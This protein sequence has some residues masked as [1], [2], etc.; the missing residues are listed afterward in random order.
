VAEDW[1]EGEEAA[2]REREGE[3]VTDLDLVGEL[4]MDTVREATLHR[5]GELE[6]VDRGDRDPPWEGDLE[7][8]G[9]WEEERECRAERLCDWVTESEKE[10]LLVRERVDWALPVLARAREGETVREGER[11]LLGE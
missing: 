1:R 8:E 11:E 6:K 5:E 10:G 9:D 4:D 3:E 2:V 7:R